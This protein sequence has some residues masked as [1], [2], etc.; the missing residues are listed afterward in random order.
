[1][2][3]SCRQKAVLNCALDVA[4]CHAVVVGHWTCADSCQR[5]RH[6][7]SPTRPPYNTGSNTLNVL[8]VDIANDIDCDITLIP[9]TVALYHFSICTDNVHLGVCSYNLRYS[10]SQ[11]LGLQHRGAVTVH[12]QDFQVRSR[13]RTTLGI[14]ITGY[15]THFN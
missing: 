9:M 14:A 12:E 1:M 5:S 15:H 2:H 3:F 6:H 11:S 4:L 13:F 8:G 7:N 10:P